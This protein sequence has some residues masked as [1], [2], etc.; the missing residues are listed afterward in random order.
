LASSD[1]G[2]GVGEHYE[3]GTAVTTLEHT[4]H[5]ATVR[6]GRHEV[7]K[8][9][10]SGTGTAPD[11]RAG[12]RFTLDDLTGAGMEG[13]YV[14]TS[15]RHAGFVRETQGGSTLHYANQFQCIPAAMTYRPARITPRPQAL[16]STAVVTGPAGETVHVDDYG[17]VKVQF[18]WDRQGMKDE[19]SSAWVRV[20]SPM[21]GGGRGMIFLP[22]IGDEVLVSFIHGDPDRPVIIGSLYNG[23]AAPPYPLPENKMISGITSSSAP[24]GGMNEITMDDTAGNESISINAARDLNISAQ[25]QVSINSPLSINGGT[26]LGRLQAGQVTV[27]SSSTRATIATIT[28]PRAFTAVPKVIATPSG[29]PRESLGESFAATVRSVSTIACQVNIIRLD[30]SIGWAQSLQ[31][32]WIAWE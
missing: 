8:A 17:R 22:R 26:V 12:R 21:A 18:H 11:L 19:N 6:Q 20:T 29:D 10:V 14:I 5:L 16:P 31:L 13:D 32:N 2:A 30:S 3:F 1:G 15:V 7:E 9:L 24:G 27:G 25:R 28:F 23:S 4:R